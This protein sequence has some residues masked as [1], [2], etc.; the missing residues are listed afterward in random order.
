MAIKFFLYVISL[1]MLLSGCSAV[2]EHNGIKPTQLASCPYTPNCINSQQQG[3]HH[4][5]PFVMKNPSETNWNSIVAIIIATPGTTIVDN[6]QGY[7]HVEV[8][9]LIFRFT[10]DFEIL[11]A[12]NGKTIDI[13]SA[14]RFGFSDIG[15]NARRI[16]TLRNI[17]KSKHLI[18]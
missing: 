9:S 12:K 8:S 18:E 3:F 1:S 6:T 16:E 10:D 2:S 17:L 7:L 11:L 5:A 14:S 4:T 15:V 13:R